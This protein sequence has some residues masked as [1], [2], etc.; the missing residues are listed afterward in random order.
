[1]NKS[2]LG[3]FY[4]HIDCIYLSACALSQSKQIGTKTT[5]TTEWKHIHEFGHLKTGSLKT[6]YDDTD[7][8][9]ANL[10]FD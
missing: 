10:V 9:N 6:E 1:M 4:P 5:E 3:Y 2:K 8:E 7:L